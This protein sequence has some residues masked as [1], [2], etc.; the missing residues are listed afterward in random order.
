[1]SITKILTVSEEAG[2]EEPVYNFNK[3]YLKKTI[4]EPCFIFRNVSYVWRLQKVVGEYCQRG[5]AVE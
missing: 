3:N 2:G 4:K 5:R 1:M